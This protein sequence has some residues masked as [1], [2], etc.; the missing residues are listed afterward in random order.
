MD[1][2]NIEG[3][4]EAILFAKGEP[5]CLKNIAYAIEKNEEE[6]KLILDK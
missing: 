2:K 6:T 5:V 1:I 3:I 4:I